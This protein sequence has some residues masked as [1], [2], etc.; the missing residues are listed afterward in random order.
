[1]DRARTVRTWKIGFQAAARSLRVTR[2]KARRPG[3]RRVHGSPKE[4]DQSGNRSEPAVRNR[5]GES[6]CIVNFPTAF[7][8][9]RASI[10][11]GSRV[12]LEADTEDFVTESGDRHSLSA[13]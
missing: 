5:W 10:P 4:T 2:S 11:E 12:S 7:D 1:M 13:G 3:L 6:V 9:Y 8:Q